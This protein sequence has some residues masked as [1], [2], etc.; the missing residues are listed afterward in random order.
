MAALVLDGRKAAA[1]I[2][3]ELKERV[4]RLRTRGIVPRLSLIRVGEDPASVVYVRTKTKACAETGIESDLCVLSEGATAVEISLA[5]DSR[6][7]DPA[8]HGILLQL[9]LPG[10][11]D[12][13]PQLMRIAPEKD[14]DGFHPVNIGRLCLGAPGFVPCTPLGVFELIRRNG[15]DLSGLHVAVVGRSTT[16]GRPLA[17]L[18][19]TKAAGCNATVSLLHTGSRE[20]WLLSR[21]ADVVIAAAGQRALVDA[22]WIRPG[23]VVVDVG[24]HRGEDGRL[25]G[26]V[27][28]GPVGE[29]AGWLSPVPGG[30]G[31]MTVACLLANTVRAAEMLSGVGP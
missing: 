30:V 11:I 1:E 26:D 7:S 13:L 31:P 22:R 8:V 17:N 20:P 28:A 15:I 27:D 6:V 18:L 9:P 23:A 14:V 10:G 24:I 21:T 5:I 19:S 3:Q 2:R 29:I 25:T 16:V 4:D 12:P